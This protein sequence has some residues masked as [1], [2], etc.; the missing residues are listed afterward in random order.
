MSESRRV[1]VTTVPFGEVDRRPLDLLEDAGI[2]YVINPLGRKLRPEEAAEMIRDFEVVVAG[3]EPITDK[4]LADAPRL[5][6]IARVGVGLDSVDLLAARRR[7]VRVTYTPEAPAPAVAELT[8]G[9]MV[10]AL[11]HISRADRGLRQGNWRRFPGRRLET[12]VIG[13]VGIGRIGRR[14]VNLLSGFN[15]RIL[16]CDPLLDESFATQRGLVPASLDTILRECDVVSLHVPLS[17][18]TENLVAAAQLSAMK[19][20]AVLI[21]TSRGGI[22]NEQDLAESLQSGHLG[23]AAVD[24]FRDEPYVGP[25]TTIENCILTAHMGSMSEDCRARMEIEAV[26]E[27]VRYL[28]GRPLLQAVPEDEYASRA[29]GA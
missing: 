9:L 13:L 22:V 8:I 25:L 16:V 7:G 3:T 15:A 23:A 12:S 1:L 24:V 27:A 28:T 20:G 17:P 2:P 19:K 6:L 5:E 18:S 4:V 14:V 11:R 10:D 26:E 29:G 21:N